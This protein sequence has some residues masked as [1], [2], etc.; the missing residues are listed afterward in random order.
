MESGWMLKLLDALTNWT[1]NH[2]PVIYGATI[3]ACVAAAFGM[4]RLKSEAHIV[5]DLPKSDKVYQDLK[6]FETNFHGVMPLELVIDAKKK[7]LA[8]TPTTLLKIDSLHEYL[9]NFDEIGHAL[10]ITEGIKFAVQAQFGGDSASYSLPAVGLASVGTTLRKHKNAGA[11]DNNNP[12]S[13]LLSSF[14]DSNGQQTRISISMADV[15]SVR[16][17]VLLDSITRKTNELFPK[18]KY[19]VTQTGTSIVFLEGSKFIINS[20]RDSLLLAFAMIFVCMVVLF[21]SW[22]IV[23]ISLVVNIVPLLITAGIMGWANVPLKPSTVLVFSIALGITVDVTIRFLVNYKQEMELH[24]EDIASTVK[25]T[26]HDTGLSII[27]TSLILIAGF[28]V[29]CLSQF[30]GTKSLGFLTSITLL[31]AMVTN[32]TLQP[33]LLLWIDKSKKKKTAANTGINRD[34]PLNP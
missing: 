5:D 3:V 11:A 31:L 27:Y 16:L 28:G 10:A 9:K 32:L 8:T 21:R 34:N 29:F 15:G 19:T 25:R 2:R 23:M 22:R 17:P 18:D 26:I 24:G 6:F 33:A 4:A 20:L 13:K 30:D 12:F 7:Y 1:F 14:I